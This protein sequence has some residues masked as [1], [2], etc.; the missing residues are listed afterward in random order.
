MKD[1][2]SKSYRV[3]TQDLTGVRLRTQTKSQRCKNGKSDDSQA[4]A[5]TQNMFQCLGY[6][7]R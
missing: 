2:I 6:L 5:G 4:Y 1:E 3:R 7:F